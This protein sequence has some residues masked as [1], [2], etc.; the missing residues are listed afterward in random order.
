MKKRNLLVILL[1]AVMLFTTACG[2]GASPKTFTKSGM[3]IELTDR[4]TEKDILTYTASYQSFD[5]AVMALKEEYSYFEGLDLD[6]DGY[7]E[8][9]IKTNSMDCEVQHKDG[10][11]YFCYENSASGK[12]FA[13]T[14]FVYEGEDAYW[15]IQFGCEAKNAEKFADTFLGYAKTVKV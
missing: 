15:M 5:T 12:D 6:L 9:I 7:A 2:L 8:L 3:S 11:T 14:A 13:Y 10:L 4:F 1:C